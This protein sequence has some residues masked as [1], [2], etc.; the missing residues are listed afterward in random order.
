MSGARQNG[1]HPGICR[2]C[3]AYCPILVTVENGRPVKVVGNPNDT[4]YG[5]YICPKGRALP[6]QHNDSGRLLSAMRRLPSGDFAPI[7]T[8][9]AVAEVAARISEL[10]DRYGPDAVALYTGTGPVSNPTGQILAYSFFRAL[11]SK[12]VFSSATLDKPAANT[13]TALHGNWMAGAQRF[14]TA[15][16]WMVI[17]ANPVLAKSNGVPFHNPGVRL[18]EARQRGMKLIVIDPRQT[19]TAKRAWLHLQPRPGEDPTLLA[20]IINIILS[21]GLHDAAFVAGNA[22]GLEALRKAVAPFTPDYAARRAGV[23]I[24]DLQSAARAFA[25]AKRGCA[26]CSTGPSFAAHSDLS[27]YLALCLNTLCGRWGRAGERAAFQNI[28]LPPYTPKAQPYPPYPVFGPTRLRAHGLRQN[29]SGMPAAAL[30]DEILMDGEGQIKAMFCVGGNPMQSWPLPEKARAA[31]QKLDLLVVFDYRMTLTAESADYI[32]APPLTLEI[33]GATYRVESLKYIGVSRGYEIPWAQYAEAVADPPPEAD[34]MDDGAFFFRMAQALG[35]QLEWISSSGFGPHVENPPRRFQLDMN[36]LPTVAEMIALSCAGSRIPLDEIRQHPH[37]HL[38]DDVNVIIAPREADCTA[39]LQ[40][41]DPM[42]MAEIAEVRREWPGVSVIDAAYPFR[43]MPRRANSFMNS[44]GQ[45]LATLNR[46]THH[47]P[48]HLHPDD[49]AELGLAEGGLV[50]LRSSVGV[51]L[52]VVVP[53]PTLRRRTVTTFQGFG[54]RP[55]AQTDTGAFTGSSVTAL[56]GLD[57]HD[58]IT[59]MPLMSGVPVAV[60]AVVP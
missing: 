60:E 16:T 48:M 40:L 35:L 28:M 45:T 20:A 53:D 13:S 52:G 8:G 12:M 36:R 41:G 5:G 51:A 3:L 15:D 27:Y 7:S 23:P 19:E 14:E 55:A 46:G 39:M 17:G 43:L 54:H 56:I 11:G 9:D 29:A 10:V 47:N 59:G 34:L 2:N 4:P 24:E 57:H 58:P 50:R 25:A 21:E 22:D 33:P 26:V 42:M 49:I 30:A 32:I 6:E 18:K 1:A 37:G 31:L 44:V 38:Y